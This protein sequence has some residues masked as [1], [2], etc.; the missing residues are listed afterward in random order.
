MKAVSLNDTLLNEPT[1]T[2]KE[3]L[4]AAADPATAVVQPAA[5]N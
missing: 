5:A 2:G 1:A 3:S 4:A